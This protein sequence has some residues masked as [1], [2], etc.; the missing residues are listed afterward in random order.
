MA[1]LHRPLKDW[2]MGEN[3]S[4]DFYWMVF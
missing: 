4:S 3:K 2:S 1:K